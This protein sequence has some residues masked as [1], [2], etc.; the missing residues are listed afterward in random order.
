MPGMSQI[1]NPHCL[2]KYKKHATVLGL[3]FLIGIWVS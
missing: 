2:Q 1:S 3:V